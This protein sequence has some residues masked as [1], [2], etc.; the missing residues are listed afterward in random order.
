[1]NGAEAVDVNGGG[2]IFLPP[3]GFKEVKSKTPVWGNQVTIPDG[4]EPPKDGT[5]EWTNQSGTKTSSTTDNGGDPD[6]GEEG[7]EENGKDTE[8]MVVLPDGKKHTAREFFANAFAEKEKEI[9]DQQTRLDGMVELLRSGTIPGDP[10]KKEGETEKKEEETPKLEH[11]SF[12]EDATVEANEKFIQ[13]EYNKLVDS[14]NER[15]TYWKTKFD[16]QQT[17]ME[18]QAKAHKELAD[19]VGREQWKANLTRVMAVTGLKEEEIMAKYRET[20]IADA[21]VLSDL[22]LGE[23]AKDAIIK[24]AEENAEKARLEG[25]DAITSTSSGGGGGGPET[26]QP[27][28]G[29]NEETDYTPDKLVTKYNLFK[30][31]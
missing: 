10:D 9:A 16:E 24:E 21:D 3:G 14:F 17:E 20:R 12:D 5:V 28:R 7:G 19:V 11:M 23:R 27:L 22:I 30:A 31:A 4:A 15:E 13:G 26:P 1:M 6:G 8:P 18:E 25:R 29:L 2:T